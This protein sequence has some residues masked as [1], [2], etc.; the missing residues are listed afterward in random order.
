MPD[1][2]NNHNNRRKEVR[3]VNLVQRG[4]LRENKVRLNNNKKMKRYWLI[5]MENL[6]QKTMKGDYRWRLK[7]IR[8]MS[9]IRLKGKA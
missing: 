7:S 8:I 1:N 3:E 6:I 9:L 5:Q 4:S 2:I